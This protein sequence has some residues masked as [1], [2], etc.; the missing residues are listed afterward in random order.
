MLT[1]KDFRTESYLK[2]FFRIN[3]SNS[4][5]RTLDDWFGRANPSTELCHPLLQT[6]SLVFQ[7]RVIE[8]EQLLDEDEEKFC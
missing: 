7:L 5:I 8:N 4:Q 2:I 6:S 1:L 3:F